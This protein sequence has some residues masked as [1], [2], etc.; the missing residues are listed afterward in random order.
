VATLGLSAAGLA[1]LDACGSSPAAPI[2]DDA[3]LET[4]TI[5]LYKNTSICPAPQYL[6][7]ETLKAEGFTE[8]QY[9]ETNASDK[10]LI[11]GDVD[12]GQA[13][14]ASL[15]PHI[16]GAAPLVIL[17]GVHVGCF[18]LFVTEHINSISDLK[19]RQQP[20]RCW[21]ALSTCSSPVYWRM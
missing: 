4:T 10:T 21:E 1:L 16:E 20:Y 12:I 5:R 15:L 13:F 6:A 2:P 7:Q 17:S 18:E 19:G 3:V 14:A 11:S 9:I 8:V